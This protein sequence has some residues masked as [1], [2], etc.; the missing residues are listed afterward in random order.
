[1]KKFYPITLFAVVLVLVSGWA[2]SVT[3]APDTVIQTSSAVQVPDALK[4]IVSALLLGAVTLGLNALF[5]TF[6]LD[7]RG[8]SAAVA[9]AF[10]GFLIAQ[11]QGDRKSVV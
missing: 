6:G 1:M 3:P 8:V 11:V 4:T 5:N 10:S 9:V 2:A 7:L